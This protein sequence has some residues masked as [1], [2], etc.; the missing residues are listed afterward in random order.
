[1]NSRLTLGRRTSRER[2]TRALDF[3]MKP[4]NPEAYDVVLCAPRH[5]N[6]PRKTLLYSVHSNFYFPREFSRARRDFYHRSNCV[7][8]CSTSTP[9]PPP[10]PPPPPRPARPTPLCPGRRAFAARC[11]T[12]RLFPSMEKANSGTCF[13]Y[14]LSSRFI[15]RPSLKRRR[16][17]REE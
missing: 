9:P 6:M 3:T 8:F 1:M 2:A 13:H 5:Q 4:E 16:Q 7:C 14:R 11:A 10:P 17:E 15:Y 12:L